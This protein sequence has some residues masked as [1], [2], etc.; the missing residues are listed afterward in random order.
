MSDLKEPGFAASLASDII[1]G[2]G[3]VFGGLSEAQKKAQIKKTNGIFEL[4]VSK[5][6]KEAVWTIDRDQERGDRQER[7]CYWKARRRYYP[8][9]T[10][11][12]FKSETFTDLATGKLN[13]QKAFL[14]GKLKVRPRVG[15]LL[16]N[17]VAHRLPLHYNLICRTGNMMLATKLEDVLKLAKPKAKL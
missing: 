12:V 6:G 11:I 1:T 7:A 9:W 10:N 5:D 15:L 4:R 3:G 2:L 14:T 17:D 8:I 16:R 13:G